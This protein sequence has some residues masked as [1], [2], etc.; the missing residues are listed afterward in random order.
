M[1]IGLNLFHNNERTYMNNEWRDVEQASYYFNQDNGKVLGMIF[2]Y[3]N[4][5]VIWGAKIFKDRIPV[6]NDNEWILGQFVNAESA[7][8]NVEQYWEVQ[9]RTLLE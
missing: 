6:T 2:K 4:Q 5:N 1:D 9:S 3:A 7:K 8:R